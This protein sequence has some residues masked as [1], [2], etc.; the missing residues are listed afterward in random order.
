MLK[1]DERQGREMGR[2]EKIRG[3][4]NEWLARTAEDAREEQ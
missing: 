2:N 3:K 1:W 4:D